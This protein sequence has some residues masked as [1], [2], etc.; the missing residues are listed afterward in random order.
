MAL[1]KPH[2][3]ESHRIN[4]SGDTLLLPISLKAEG[5]L[6]LFRKCD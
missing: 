3:G 6:R 5:R 4:K 1:A 2:V